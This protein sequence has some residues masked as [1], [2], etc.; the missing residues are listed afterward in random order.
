MSVMVGV[1]EIL[2]ERV[3]RTMEQKDV[4]E[5][6]LGRCLLGECSVTECPVEDWIG[7]LRGKAESIN[8][9]ALTL[10][11][12]VFHALS[13]PLRV[14]IVKLL[15]MKGEL[16]ACEIQAAIGESQSSTSYH[17]G[18]LREAGIV[19]AEKHGVWAYYRLSSPAV[20]SMI[21]MA[22]EISR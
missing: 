3:R 18:L 14:K 9:K 6:Q 17:I 12:R 21:S 19:T 13:D 11:A 2:F 15:A 4:L 1:S 22:D 20:L 5:C 7:E 8:K 10:E 16:C